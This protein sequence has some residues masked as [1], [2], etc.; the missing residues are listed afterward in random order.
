M[1]PLL[2][3]VLVARRAAAGI[4]VSND[5][6]GLQQQAQQQLL[7]LQPQCSS[8][9]TW[10]ANYTASS[11]P[12]LP[13]ETEPPQDRPIHGGAVLAAWRA[14]CSAP[15]LSIEEVFA[16]ATRLFSGSQDGALISA[17][18]S[19]GGTL[20]TTL[21]TTDRQALALALLQFGL[22]EEAKAMRRRAQVL[23][24]GTAAQLDLTRTTAD[25]FSPETDSSAAHE[26]DLVPAQQTMRDGTFVR[27][28]TCL[29]PA[30]GHGERQ[31]NQDLLRQ[32][33]QP[34]RR[35]VKGE[36]HERCAIGMMDGLVTD[37]EAFRLIGHFLQVLRKTQ[38]DA[39]EVKGKPM[40]DL[41]RS[42]ANGDL[43]DHLFFVRLVERLR[44]AASAVFGVPLKR[45]RLAVRSIRQFC[46]DHE[47]M[48]RS[49]YQQ[50]GNLRLACVRRATLCQRSGHD[51]TANQL[52]T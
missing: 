15:L 50:Y 26:I 49:S 18:V 40:I 1:L 47:I 37:A 6:E 44:S 35:C 24:E 14:E 4:S 42:V 39:K 36:C 2:L 28:L 25:R 13:P 11:P 3:G 41:A 46:G 31:Y 8:I 19:G 5:L 20:R 16:K 21:P 52:Y 32:Q 45:L 51:P 29:R 17:A 33:L 9:E 12:V 38:Q 10:W 7:H 30:A 34:G 23:V 48:L 43:S 22:A 27:N